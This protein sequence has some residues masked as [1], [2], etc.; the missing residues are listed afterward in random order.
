MI[1]ASPPD[2]R[3]IV[4]DSFAG[5]AFARLLG[6][7]LE[8][9]EAGR[10]VIGLA[11]RADLT[12]QDGFVHAGVVT[13]I[14]DNAGGYAALS[15]MPEGARV[16]TAELKI[17]LLAPGRGHRLRADGRVLKA[18][19]TLTVVRAEIV[20]IEDGRETLI[21]AMQGTIATLYPR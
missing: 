6:A 15:L 21:A 8:L 9:V 19:R 18:G 17:N 1:E 14:A 2:F 20:A 3:R 11:V 13:T 16:L 4:A 12:Q 10:C 5:Q 7:E